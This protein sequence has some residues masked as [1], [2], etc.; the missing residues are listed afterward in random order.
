MGWICSLKE[1]RG[2]AVVTAATFADGGR[3]Q[4]TGSTSPPASA[5]SSK[6]G[7]EEAGRGEPGGTPAQ[8]GVWGW[9]LMTRELD[10]GR[11]AGEVI[12]MRHGV[13]G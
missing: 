7:I 10:A 2:A 4:P 9:G 3:R 8:R 11:R 6:A 13:N 1:S 12:F 5:S